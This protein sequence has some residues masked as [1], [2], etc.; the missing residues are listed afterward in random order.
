[1]KIRHFFKKEA[2]LTVF[3]A[4]SSR[5]LRADRPEPRQNADFRSIQAKRQR[6]HRQMTL[7]VQNFDS[8][9]SLYGA[10]AKAKMR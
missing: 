10:W 6:C 3:L 2:G 9:A 7:S 4:D 5:Q 8:R 1:M